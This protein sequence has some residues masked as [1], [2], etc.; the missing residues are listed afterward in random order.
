MIKPIAISYECNFHYFRKIKSLNDDNRNTLR[1][2]RY[3]NLKICKNK[4]N[5][6]LLC[7]K[8]NNIMTPMY[9]FY[10]RVNLLIFKK[11]VAKF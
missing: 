5:A 4:F 7:K 3:C 10:L 9:V 11:N 8:L 6:N 2:N 1:F